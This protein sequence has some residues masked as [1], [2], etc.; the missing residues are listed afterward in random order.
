MLIS[1][2]RHTHT[3][4]YFFQFH[5]FFLFLHYLLH[6]RFYL[7]HW[8]VYKKH[9]YISSFILGNVLIYNSWDMCAFSFSSFSFAFDE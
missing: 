1:Q 6:F 5:F 2:F 8:A 4:T 7:R 3:E 9:L